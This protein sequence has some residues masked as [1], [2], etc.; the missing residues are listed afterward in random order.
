MKQIRLL[1]LAGVFVGGLLSTA[2]AALV[3]LTVTPDDC[4]TTYTCW[5]SNDNSNLS[6]SDVETITGATGLLS[7]YKQDQGAGS[8][9]GTFADSYETTFDN[10]PADPEDALIELLAGE[11]PITCG[12][13]FLVVKDGNNAPAQYIF[14]L[15]GLGM[16]NSIDM[17]DFWPQNGAISHVEIFGSVSAVPVPAAI[18]LFGTALVGF[19][20]MARR[21]KV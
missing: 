9:S 17:N 4:N 20:G 7:Y 1:A 13:C 21:T 15:S 2:E 19:A 16:L 14:D 18:W 12:T 5:T 11:D 10:I 8:D 3:D 6:A